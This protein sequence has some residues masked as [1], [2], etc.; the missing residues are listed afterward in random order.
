MIFIEAVHRFS[1]PQE[2]AGPLMLS[3]AAG[4]L[5]I[6]IDRPGHFARRTVR[7]PEHAGRLAAPA[8]RR[9]GQ[10]RHARGRRFDLAARLVPG[11]IR[12]ASIADRTAR[13]LL[14]VEFTRK[15][16]DR[17]PDGEHAGASELDEVRS[18][19]ADGPGAGEVHDLHIWTI[20][21]GM[22]SLSAHVVL[23]AGQ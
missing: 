20:T 10:R 2:V 21:S 6:N 7:K 14:V 1:E 23:T 22:D 12:L 16:G 4:G 19:I 18:A 15:A 9:A 13:D 11:P 3:I 5:A 8:D 17:H